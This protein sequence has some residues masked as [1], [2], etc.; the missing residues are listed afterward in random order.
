MILFTTKLQDYKTTI[1]QNY[2]YNNRLTES[3]DVSNRMDEGKEGEH[4]A[5]DLMYL[6]N[7][8]ER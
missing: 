3:E 4:S 8:V 6:N 1:L 5:Q 7:R 2:N